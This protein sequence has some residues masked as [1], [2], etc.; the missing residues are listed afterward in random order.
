MRRF[1]NDDD[2]EAADFVR[3]LPG[4][5]DTE[6]RRSGALSGGQK[7]RIAIARALV[8]EPQILIL[9]EATSA[10]D[11]ATEMAVTAT[12]DRVMQGRTVIS[13]THRLQTAIGYD[14]IFVMNQGRLVE[15]GTHAELLAHRGVYRGLWDKQSGFTVSPEGDVATVS[16]ARLR[17][18]PLFA[19]FDDD[20]L[21]SLAQALVPERYRS[22]E[23]IVHE[24][25]EGDRF[26]LIARGR[27]N[28]VQRAP[29]GSETVLRVMTDGDHFGEIA[30]VEEVPRTATVR[31]AAPTICLSLS[32]E[33]FSRLLADDAELR[34]TIAAVISERRA[35]DASTA[36]EPSASAA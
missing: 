24:G 9:D 17:Q 30:I 2:D 6:I 31:A 21:A 34:R 10:L 27:V 16:P 14:R 32:R 19:A 7:Q 12:L 13:V 26:Y 20:R 11:P 22:G 36:V 28:A 25:A 1:N 15:Q 33:A 35:S 29:D 23:V 18:I 8:R 5:L 4:G 3:N